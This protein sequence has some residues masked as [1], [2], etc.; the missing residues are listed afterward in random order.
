MREYSEVIHDKHKPQVDEKKKEELMR[1]IE[2]DM[3]RKKRAKKVYKQV[4][5]E[6]TN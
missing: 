4:V 5:D 3:L 1:Y 2:V 6:T